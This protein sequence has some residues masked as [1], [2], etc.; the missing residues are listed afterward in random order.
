MITLIMGLPGSGKSTLSALI[1]KK[2]HKKGI[3]VY[4]N[5]H[6]LGSRYLDINWLGRNNLEDCAL[7]ID[8]AQ[9]VYDNRN[10]KNFREE[11]KY[12]YSNHRHYR[13]EIYLISQ[14]F[15]DLD[16]KLRR[17]AS[18]I[19]ILQPTL[20]GFTH[21]KVQKVKQRFGVNK[22]GNDIIT[23]YTINGLNTRYYRKKP[24]WAY[25]DSFE[26]KELPPIPDDRLWGETPIK[27]PL[28]QRLILSFTRFKLYFKTKIDVV[29]TLTK[30]KVGN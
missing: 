10:F 2:Y 27:L 8:E 29:A 21:I 23:I 24:A 20:L 9:L 4:S 1:S 12:F 26:K 7:I 16:I 19:W 6:I 14:S 15:E 25:F 5:M 3:P 22:D 18:R 28:K 30:K 11:W 17:L 13:V